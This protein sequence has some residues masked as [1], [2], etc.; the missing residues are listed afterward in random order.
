LIRENGLYRGST[1]YIK[2]EIFDIN[3]NRVA[4]NTSNLVLTLYRPDGT[5]ITYTSGFEPSPDGSVLR[6]IT[7][8]ESEPTGIWRAVWE[9]VDEYGNRWVEEMPFV[10]SEART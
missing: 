5:A 8:G 4:V 10:V 9:Y 6:A 2:F 7:I 3:G 1:K